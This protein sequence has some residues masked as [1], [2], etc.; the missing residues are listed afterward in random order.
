MSASAWNVRTAAAWPCRCASRPHRERKPSTAGPAGASACGSARRRRGVGVYLIG[1]HALLQKQESMNRR[2]SG[3]HEDSVGLCEKHDELGEARA[4]AQMKTKQAP[5]CLY[6]KEGARGHREGRVSAGCGARPSPVSSPPPTQTN[7]V[8]VGSRATGK[9]AACGMGS[10]CEAGDGA[11]ACACAR[12]AV[13][14]SEGREA[15]PFGRDKTAGWERAGA[16]RAAAASA[17]RR[18]RIAIGRKAGALAQAASA[19]AP[20]AWRCRNMSRANTATGRSSSEA[21]ESGALRFS[22]Q[23]F[24][25]RLATCLRHC[26]ASN[27]ISAPSEAGPAED[28]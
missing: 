11:G 8:A 14:A 15:V 18:A 23:F 21:V 9:S 20:R 16:A 12:G 25:Q 24:Q 1:A 10:T 19:V 13:G 28:V 4:P 2:R 17:G 3:A 5:L 22:I 6:T 27:A 26:A 7:F